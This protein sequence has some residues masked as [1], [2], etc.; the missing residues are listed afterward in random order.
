MNS[1]QCY[2]ILGLKNDT[3]FKEVKSAYRSLALQL[4][5]DKNTSEKDGKKFK[6]VTEAYQILRTEYKRTIKPSHD[7]KR[8]YHEKNS[9]T[10]YTFNSK[11]WWGAKPTDKPPEQDWGKYTRYAESA[12]QEFWRYYEKVF[13][14]TY[15]KSRAETAQVEEVEEPEVELKQ[16]VTANVDKSLC[17]GCCSCEVMAPNVFYV[18]KN[19]RTNPKSSVINSAGASPQRILDAAQT[20]PTKAISVTD[21][22]SKRRLFPW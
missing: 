16:Q 22:E 6:L 19:A 21:A 5:P 12:Y 2:Q 13:W 18:D 7:M 3:S 17:I 10:D 8:K 1:F 14:E 4:H 20:C 15:E 11:N 9:Q